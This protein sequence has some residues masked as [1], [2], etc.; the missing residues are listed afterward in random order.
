MR[1]LTFM[2]AFNKDMKRVSKYP[3]FDGKLLK[4]Y[5]DNLVNGIAL[6]P[7][8]KDHP[9]SKSSPSKYKGFRD[10]PLSPDICVIYERT[11]DEVTLYRI[12]KHN[13][14]GLTENLVDIL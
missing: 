2:N 10:F 9:L 12:G 1:K 4:E 14:L 3:Q 8:A 7:K 11:S 5:C 6:P 13:N